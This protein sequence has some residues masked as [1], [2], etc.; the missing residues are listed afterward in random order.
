MGRKVIWIGGGIVVVAL[1][2]RLNSVPGFTK[3][4]FGG[5]TTLATGLLG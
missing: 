2:Y 4:I 5:T 3:K 1:I